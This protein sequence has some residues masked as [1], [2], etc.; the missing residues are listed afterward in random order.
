MGL[1]ILDGKQWGA[2]EHTIDA[3]Y[4]RLVSRHRDEETAQ[5]AVAELMAE[6]SDYVLETGEISYGVVRLAKLS[7]SRTVVVDTT[8]IGSDGNKYREVETYPEITDIGENRKNT[9]ADRGYE[10]GRGCGSP[11]CVGCQN[12]SPCTDV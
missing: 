3:L 10:E 11:M 6:Q 2:V 4:P 5:A 12:G 7:V 9:V 1:D 8:Y